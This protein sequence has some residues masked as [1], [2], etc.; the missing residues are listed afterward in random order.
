MQRNRQLI[1]CRSIH[2]C[3]VPATSETVF[4]N[5]GTTNVGKELILK[6]IMIFK[7]TLTKKKSNFRQKLTLSFDLS[8]FFFTLISMANS[9]WPKMVIGHFKREPLQY[10]HLTFRLRSD[11]LSN[12]IKNHLHSKP[13]LIRSDPRFK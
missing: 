5:D 6:N 11:L 3:D 7:L 12:S 1:L 13:P 9:I 8:Y 4:V 10:W 2:Y